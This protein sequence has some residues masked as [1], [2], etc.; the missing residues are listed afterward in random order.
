MKG[1]KI[2][3]DRPSKK[4]GV[5]ANKD[6]VNKMKLSKS[7]KNIIQLDL[8]YKFIKE[9]PSILELCNTLDISNGNVLRCCKN[10][11]RTYKKFIWQYKN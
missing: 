4:K 1:N 10:E 3:C 8:N 7:T 9:W 6:S 5:P 2:N 11:R